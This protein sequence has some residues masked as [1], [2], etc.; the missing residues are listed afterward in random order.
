[1]ETFELPPLKED[2]MLVKMVVDSICMSTYKAA[3]QGGE[4]RRVPDD[5]SQNPTITGHEFC[6]EVVEVGAKWKG[7]YNVGQRFII[8]TAMKETFDAIGYSFRN[9]GGNSTYGIIPGFIIE[10]GY[11]IPYTGDAFYYG[12]LV[13]PISCVVAATHATYH[14][15]Q[16]EYIHEMGVKEGGRMLALAALGP[17]GLAFLDYVIHRDQ[18]P[19]LLVVTDI[20]DTRLKRAERLLPPGM[21]AEKGIR[22]V[23]LNTKDLED[24]VKTMKD[25]SDGEGF[26][27]IF[28]FAPVSSLVK[29]ADALLAFDGCL[30]FFAGPSDPKFS[31]E[32]N[33]YNVHYSFTHVAA[34]VGGNV[35]DMMEGLRM[36]TDK[37][38]DPSI[39]VT[40]VGGLDSAA[41]SI[42]NLPHIPGGKK[43]IYN[44]IK[45]PLTAIDDFA[46]KGKSDPMFAKLAEICGRNNGLWNLEA[47]NY[48]LENAPKINP[49]EY[50]V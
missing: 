8:Q 50:W 5:V 7:K 23:Y 2:E 32:L 15:R 22:L 40:H 41:E 20:D 12:A 46:E 31:G 49:D 28:L 9:I 21:A 29:Q 34:T 38:L 3:Q 39:L 17:M 30:N 16:G 33:F 4:H 36:A 18:R 10:N 24:P 1:M 35:D 45:L 14:T 19:G 37:Q 47:E 25:M 6:G 44:H 43:L 48:L 11:V 26:S 42:L 13:E 27:D